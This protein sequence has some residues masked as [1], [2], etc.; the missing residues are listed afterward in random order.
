MLRS[1]RIHVLLVE[2]DE[3][4]ASLVQDHLDVLQ[5]RPVVWERVSTRAA[6]IARL[7]A[8]VAHDA[9]R[10]A[11]TAST[12]AGADGHLDAVL[13]DLGLPDSTLTETLPTV[14]AAADGVPIVVLTSL[15][16]LNLALEAVALGA[17]DYLVKSQM[18]SELLLRTVRYAVERTRGARELSAAN[19]RLRAE[20]VE[21]ELAEVAL[22]EREADLRALNETLERLVGER[23]DSLSRANAALEV[24]NRD[25]QSFAYVASHDLQEPLRKIQS[26]GGLLTREYGH[27]LGVDGQHYVGRITVAAERLSALV[28]DLLSFSRVGTH[29]D[30]FQAV[31]LARVAADVAEELELV[32]RET[33][34]SVEIGTLP[35]VH[36][37]GV[38]LRRLV[39]NLVEN[40]L[41]YRRDG[42]APLVRLV[43]GEVDDDGCVVFTVE[44][45]GIGFDTRHAERIFEPFQRLHG[46]AAYEGTG[47]GLAIVQRIAERHGGAVSAESMPGEGSRFRVTLR[48]AEET[49][50]PA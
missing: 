12:L 34:A 30:A 32:V 3:D 29:G 18:S 50:A 4:H 1:P 28:R 35:R 43:M 20:V 47:M 27:A 16:D 31:D 45:N 23:T 22:R 37:D 41:K 48:A 11:G 21:R 42:V 39:H 44:D 40:A 7:R 36:G 49:A 2:D 26:F 38:Q 10:V 14:L 5:G 25:L 15:Y 46:K 8:A 17:Q 19:R 6:A 24:R 9:A 33:G 13:L